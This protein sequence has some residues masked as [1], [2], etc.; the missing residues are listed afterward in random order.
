MAVKTYYGRS[1]K[2][3]SSISLADPIQAEGRRISIVSG[4]VPFA[5]G[6]SIASKVYLGKVPSSAIIDPSSTLYHEALGAGCLA[7][8]GFEK[9]GSSTINGGDKSAV[10]ATG[11]DVSAAG[12]K[13]GVAAIAT[14]TLGQ[15]VYEWLGYT[16]DPGVEFDIVLT[17]TAAAAAA[18]SISMFYRASKK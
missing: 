4:P 10:L 3:P 13:S 7:K 17:L 12:T 6:D 2:D 1:R 9:D 5:N 14:N 8:I 18:G 11:L 16:R 15:K